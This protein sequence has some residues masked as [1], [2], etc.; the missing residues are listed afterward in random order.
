MTSSNEFLKNLVNEEKQQIKAFQY[1]LVSK[2][3]WFLVFG[4]LGLGGGLMYTFYSPSKYQAKCTILVQNESNALRGK[5]FFDDDGSLRGINVQDHIGVLKSSSLSKQVLINLNWNVSWYQ[6]MPF[7]NQDLYGLAPFFVYKTDRRENPN[8]FPLFVKMISEEEYM[9]RSDNTILESSEISYF[10]AKGKFG[11]PFENEHFSFVLEKNND[12]IVPLEAEFF[13]VFNNMENLSVQYADNLN[14][15]LEDLK[16][17][18]IALELKGIAAQRIVDFLN[19][20]SEEYI[21]FC[22]SEKNKISKNTIR[23]IDMQLEGVVDSLEQTGHLFSDFQ[24]KNQSSDLEREADLAMADLKRLEEEYALSERKLNYIRNLNQYINN[25]FQF[26]KVEHHLQQDFG[27]E[28]VDNSIVSPSVV[29]ITDPGLN[30][31]VLKL[32]ELYG[33]K[34]ILSYSV[35]QNEPNMLVLE[36]EIRHTKQSLKENLQ[37][38]FVN[39]ENDLSSIAR[40]MS[41]VKSKLV[42]LPKMEQKF[43]NFKRRYDLNNDLY[44]FLLKKRAEAEI[45]IASNV[46][47][48]Q[49]LDRASL[50]STN[51]VEPKTILNLIIGFLIGISMPFIFIKTRDYFNNTI[52]SIYELERETSLPVLGV[53]S[54]NRHRKDFLVCNRPRSGITESFRSLRTDLENLLA[55]NKQK[56]ISVQSVMPG[57]GKSFVSLNLAAIL[58]MNNEKVLLVEADMRKPGLNRVFGSIRSNGMSSYLKGEDAFDDIIFQTKFENLSFIPAGP[59][60]LNPA[61]LLA[62]GK[63]KGFMEKARIHYNYI[64]LD[65]APVSVVTDGLLSGKYADLNLFVLRHHFSRKEHVNYINKLVDKGSVKNVTIL[66]NDFRVNGVDVKDFGYR[67]GY[68]KDNYLPKGKI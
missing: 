13:F 3:Y 36:K 1:K 59:V 61:E 29:D 56:V 6:K 43:I 54:H 52:G 17:N 20:L 33:K 49:I 55:E 16:G 53:I 25:S 37:N 57:E 66:L 27:N 64:I 24:S 9:V 21:E 58:A 44:T 51:Q 14:V 39:T 15:T 46:P 23:F 7:F 32:G 19:E 67:S 42:R 11:V 12:V 30:N 26:S 50:M 47:N 4:I 10:E 35:K 62:N 28:L 34:E 60:P 18:L 63:F 45:T 40:Q 65:S 2:W 22:L 38:L 31:L 8:D 48:S 5:E 41:G 68:Y